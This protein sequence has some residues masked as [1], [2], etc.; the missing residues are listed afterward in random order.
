MVDDRRPLLP[1]APSMSNGI[2]IVDDNASIRNLLR[3][4]VETSTPF[5]VC[6][7]AE[8]GPEA[9]KKA[10]ELQPDL[11]LL[12][13]TMPG[14]TGTETALVLQLQQPRPKIILFTLHAEG[15]NQELASSYGID[16]VLSKSDNVATVASHITRLLSPALKTQH[17]TQRQLS[18]ARKR[19]CS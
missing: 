4:L 16:V 15:V 17:P 14:M 12:D 5:S 7:E 9:I 13:L 11:V 3:M 2:L 1:K 18:E 10:K 8:N 6:G 19:A